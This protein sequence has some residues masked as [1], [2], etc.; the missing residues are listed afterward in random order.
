MKYLVTKYHFRYDGLISHLHLS[1]RY[2][3]KRASR[4]IREI[5]AY[6]QDNR[7]RID[8]R[9]LN[10][11]RLVIFYDHFPRSTNIET[12]SRNFSWRD[13]LRKG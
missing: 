11:E 4:A 12:T 13:S 10:N 2:K 5:H 7:L 1:T 9:G 8:S 3:Y 6:S